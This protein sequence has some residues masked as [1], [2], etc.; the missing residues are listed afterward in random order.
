MDFKSEAFAT[1]RSDG[2]EPL[3]KRRKKS[4]DLVEISFDEN[5]DEQESACPLLASLH[6]IRQASADIVKVGN[7]ANVVERFQEL[8][9]ASPSELSIEFHFLT[10]HYKEYKR[11]LHKQLASQGKHVRGEWFRLPQGTNYFKLITEVCNLS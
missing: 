1:F 8:Q 11:K 7:A 4:S 5:E 9:D 3:S 2:A 6:F 10:P